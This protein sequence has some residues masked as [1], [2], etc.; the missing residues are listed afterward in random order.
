MTCRRPYA[1]VKSRIICSLASLVRPY[2]LVGRSGWSS[3][4]ET[5]SVV[6]R[7][8]DGF[9]FAVDRRRTAENELI[10]PDLAHGLQQAQGAIGVV[11]VEPGGVALAL[12]DLDMGGKVRHRGHVVLPHHALQAAGVAGVAG[13]DADVGDGLRVARFEV[14]VDDV[15][16]G[17]GLE[18]PRKRRPDIPGTAHIYPAPPTTKTMA[19]TLPPGK[20]EATGEWRNW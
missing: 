2:T 5:V 20:L 3:G 4:M 18:L 12:A 10:Y 8:G 1:R 13:D 11:V 6:F 15:R 14:V 9:G 7:D 17:G 19:Q 16:G